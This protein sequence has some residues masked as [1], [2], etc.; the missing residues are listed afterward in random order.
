[1]LHTKKNTTLKI[2]WW[3]HKEGGQHDKVVFSLVGSWEPEDN[4][5]LFWFFK[6]S[7]STIQ[8]PEDSFPS[9]LIRE[10]RIICYFDGLS[11]LKESLLT[12]WTGCNWDLVHSDARVF[13]SCHEHKYFSPVS[14]ELISSE[15]TPISPTRYCNE[16]LQSTNSA[17]PKLFCLCPTIYIVVL[18]Q[19]KTSGGTKKK[20]IYS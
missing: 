9:S 20:K 19:N 7:L 4:V 16:K 6:H 8:F 17:V 2:G 14:I 10:I 11:N 12:Y 15:N 13:G 1:M 3:I 18:Q 5:F